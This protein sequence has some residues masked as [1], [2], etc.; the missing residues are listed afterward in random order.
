MKLVK[1]LVFGDDS[2]KELIQGINKVADAVSSTMGAQGRNVIYEAVGGKP[3]ST[4]DGVTVANEIFLENPIHSLGAELLKE[5]AR[6]T[7]DEC[8]DSTTSTVVLAREIIN[9]ADKKVNEGCHPIEL[10]KGIEA[11]TKDVLNILHKKKKRLTK[12]DYFNIANISA[13]NDRELGK[14][15]SDAFKKAGASGVVLYDKSQTE[16]TY[17]RTFEGMLIERGYANKN[18]INKKETATMEVENPYLFI[19]DRTIDNFK[20]LIFLYSFIAEQQKQGKKAEVVIIG[21][22][23]PDVEHILSANRIKGNT[24]V[25]YIKA[26]A[27]ASRRKDLMEDL[28]LATGADFI[29]KERGDN[30]DSLGYDIFGQC[31]KIV[32]DKNETVLEPYPNQNKEAVDAQI[33]TLLALKKNGKDHINKSQKKFIDERIA[34]LSCSI[35]TIMVGANS[36][37]ELDEK[38]DRVDDAVQALRAAVAEGYLIGGG[39]A[40]YNASYELNRDS[41]NTKDFNEGQKIIQTA[42]RKPFRQILENAGVQDCSEVEDYIVNSNQENLGYD[43]SLFEYKDFIKNG[44]IDPYK[45]IKCALQNA[46]SV[47]GTFILTNTTITIKREKS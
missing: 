31:K 18:M 38:I 5:A 8:G 37:V 35:S 3:K 19:C 6:K 30:Y 15:I 42:I 4:K 44:I 41:R 45:A 40:L 23:A 34:K 17:I 47:A 21:E 27:H 39:L 46:S 10:K 43:V 14:I 12:K 28:A 7:V 20:E 24:Q 33:K 1:E 13:N 36:T 9:Q 29:S 25:Y 22:L 16:Q 11:A 32:S 26:P 2:R